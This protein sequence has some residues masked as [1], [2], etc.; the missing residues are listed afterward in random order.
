MRA[1]F[2]PIELNFSF[3]SF[4]L[5]LDVISFSFLFFVTNFISS[6]VILL[7]LSLFSL[8]WDSFSLIMLDNNF[9][10]FSLS[11][12][13]EIRNLY[14]LSSESNWKV[15]LSKDDILLMFE[16]GICPMT[17]FESLFDVYINTIPSK[18]I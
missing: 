4:F 14:V 3:I 16:I 6:E 13:S 17:S 7:F 9:I 18:H 11:F 8:F 15:E 1:Y 12:I 2:F 10:H 5:G